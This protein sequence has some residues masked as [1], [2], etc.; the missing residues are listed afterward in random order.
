MN[1]QLDQGQNFLN[2]FLEEVANWAPKL[3]G[4]L[5]IFII[6]YIIAKVVASIVR[7]ALQGVQLNQRLHTGHGSNI[8]QRAVPNPTNLI[9]RLVFWVIFL[10]AV[11]LGLGSLGIPLLTDL[12]HGIYAYIPNVIAALLIFL[13]ASAISAGIAGLVTSVMGDT[14]TGKIVA[15]GAPILVM[16]LAIFM[17]LNQLKIAP[18]IVTITYAALIGSVALGSAIAFGLGGRD[19]AARLLDGAYKKTKENKETIKKD[20]QRGASRASNKVDELS[21]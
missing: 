11:T 9:S 13:V 1:E 14:P 19:M 17:I 8:I 6:G 4:A 21:Y 5:L 3:I 7:R 16:G 15:T 10:G 18:E 2:D 20:V 12:I